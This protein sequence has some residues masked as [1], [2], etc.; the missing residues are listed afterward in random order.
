MIGVNK[1]VK[2]TEPLRTKISGTVYESGIPFKRL[3]DGL[4]APEPQLIRLDF[5]SRFYVRKIQAVCYAEFC[6]SPVKPGAVQNNDKLGFRTDS[7]NQISERFDA[8]RQ[9]LGPQ[10]S[11]LPVFDTDCRLECIT[12]EFAG[13]NN[14]SE[15]MRG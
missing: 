12:A 15:F 8:L 9:K 3:S 7:F 5:K 6:G 14:F 1:P 13:E 10:Q 4:V 2:P 11:L